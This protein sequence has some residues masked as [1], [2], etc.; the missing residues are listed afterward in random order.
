MV[1]HGFTFY[2]GVLLKIVT[3]RVFFLVNVLLISSKPEGY[4]A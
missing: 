1:Y 3:I 4:Y 2:D